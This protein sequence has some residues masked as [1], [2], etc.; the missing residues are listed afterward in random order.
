[1]K[2]SRDWGCPWPYWRSSETGPF[3]IFNNQQCH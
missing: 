1:M 3:I 2:A